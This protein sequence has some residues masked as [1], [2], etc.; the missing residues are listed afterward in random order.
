MR[1]PLLSSVFFCWR[2]RFFNSHAP[3]WNRLVLIIMN[4]F[5]FRWLKKKHDRN[6]MARNTKLQKICSG[7]FPD[8]G[9]AGENRQP[10]KAGLRWFFYQ[11]FYAIAREQTDFAGM[12][13]LRF[14]RAVLWKPFYG[15]NEKRYQCL[16]SNRLTRHTFRVLFRLETGQIRFGEKRLISGFLFQEIRSPP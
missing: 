6:V 12:P 7:P 11:A 16:L 3:G 8:Q 13:L 5:Y 10:S 9:L 4:A 15:L 1:N 14:A 2:S